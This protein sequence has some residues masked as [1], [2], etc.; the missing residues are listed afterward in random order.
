[1]IA[2]LAGPVLGL[3]Q[4]ALLSKRSRRRVTVEDRRDPG[5]TRY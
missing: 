4:Q 5:D 1:M 3:I 2:G